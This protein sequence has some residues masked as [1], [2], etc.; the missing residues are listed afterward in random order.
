M[1][2]FSS[3]P[4]PFTSAILDA[5]RQPRLE[6]AALLGVGEEGAVQRRHEPDYGAQDGLDDWRVAE[7]VQEAQ[8][9]LVPGR[10]PRE[11]V[12]AVLVC[13][14]LGA[15]PVAHDG[16]REVRWVRW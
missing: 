15:V 1:L 6:V 11:P 8:G 4:L 7:L 10:Q 13:P 2:N 12:F 14:A 16:V 9:L 5:R 3:S